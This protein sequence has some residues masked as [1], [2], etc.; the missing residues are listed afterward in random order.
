MFRTELIPQA[1]NWQIDLKAPILSL[2]S[3]F[4]DT[5]GNRLKTNK[6]QVLT[7]PFGVIFNPISL[8][9]LL[10]MSLENQSPQPEH[11]VMNQGLWYHYDFHSDWVA[12]EPEIL[13]QNLENQLVSVQDFLQ[14]SEF[15]LLTL[16][17]AWVYELL[18]SAQVVANCHKQAGHLFQKK[19][20]TVEAIVSDFESVF[21]KLKNYNPRIKIILTV[22]P[23]R[24]LKD[25]LELNSVSKAVLRLACYQIMSQLPDIQYFPSYEI[26]LDDLRDYRFYAADMLHP[27]AVAEDYIWQK[28]GQTYFSRATLD[29]LQKW[30][31][32]AKALQ[33]QPFQMDSPAH[34]KFLQ[35]TLK[36]LEDLKNLVDVAGEICD[37]QKMLK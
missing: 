17:T 32:L 28:F 29:F 2:G 35:E 11:F 31:K 7:N 16:G 9:K 5:M 3:C 19:L 15:I 37:L 18:E 24:H 12:Q 33:H 1:S 25:T 22:S 26:L 8:S 6:L 20:L 30:E 34:Q 27:S 21:Q 23:V 4:A 10:T 14:N 36:K 13:K